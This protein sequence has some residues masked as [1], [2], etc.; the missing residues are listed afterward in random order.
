MPI[1]ILQLRAAKFPDLGPY[2]EGKRLPFA[3]PERAVKFQASCNSNI[4]RMH[5]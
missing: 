5:E 3:H 1:A 4:H 2:D